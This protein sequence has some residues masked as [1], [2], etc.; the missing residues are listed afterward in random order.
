MALREFIHDAGTNNWADYGGMD[1]YVKQVL[2]SNNHDLF[3]TDASVK[4]TPTLPNISPTSSFDHALRGLP[5]KTTF[6]NSLVATSTSPP[7]WPGSLL[8]SPGAV[9]VVGE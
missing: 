9:V 8:M 1:V 7:L 2:G 4:A 5:S 6:T 3:Y